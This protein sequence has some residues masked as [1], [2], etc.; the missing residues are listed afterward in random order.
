MHRRRQSALD[1]SEI[2]DA[3][4]YPICQLL[5]DFEP[6]AQFRELAHELTE[7]RQR[8]PQPLGDVVVLS[9]LDLAP[10]PETDRPLTVRDEGLEPLQQALEF[11]AGTGEGGPNPVLDTLT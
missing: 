9:G 10:F 1:G 2:Q 5:H 11:S 7:P 3:T 4:L 8:A 6:S